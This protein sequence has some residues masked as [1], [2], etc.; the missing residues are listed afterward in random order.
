MPLFIQCKD[1]HRV[2]MVKS[3]LA[4][5]ERR[6][7]YVAKAKS[8]YEETLLEW[9]QFGHRAAIAHELECMA[10]IAKAQEEEQRAVKLFGAAESLRETINIPMTPF[11]RA[12]YDPEITSLRANMDQTDFTRTWSEGRALTMEQAITFALESEVLQFPKN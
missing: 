11:E 7:G 10:M 2:T 4:H 9:Q 6:Q 3:E 12:E 8:L 1:T 5:L